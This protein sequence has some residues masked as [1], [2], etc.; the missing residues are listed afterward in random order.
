MLLLNNPHNPT[1][2]AFTKDELLAIGELLDDFP[3]V[4]V[5]SDEVYDFLVYDGREH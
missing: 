1:G 2:K 3:R 5:V 4:T